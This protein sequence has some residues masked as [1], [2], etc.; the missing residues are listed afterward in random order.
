MA[1]KFQKVLVRKR[2]VFDMTWGSKFP[3][4]ARVTAENLQPGIEVGPTMLDPNEVTDVVVPV[5]LITPDT[6]VEF[7]RIAP[8]KKPV[9]HAQRISIEGDGYLRLEDVLTVYPVSR[10]AW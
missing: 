8:H 2:R 9:H 5:D 1:Q 4:N 10:S 7:D 3:F 6:A